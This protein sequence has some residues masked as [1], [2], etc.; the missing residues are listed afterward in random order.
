MNFSK[1]CWGGLDITALSYFSQLSAKV[2]APGQK[3]KLKP[4]P[5]SQTDPSNCWGISLQRD[6]L[7]VQVSSLPVYLDTARVEINMFIKSLNNK[8]YNPKYI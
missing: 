6:I 2:T 1:F 8:I 4:G 5:V 3:D 7:E